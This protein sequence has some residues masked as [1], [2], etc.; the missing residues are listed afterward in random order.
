MGVALKSRPAQELEP[1]APLASNL[2]WLLAQASHVMI[3]EMTAAFAEMGVSPRGHCVLSAASTGDFTQKEL[4]TMVGLDKTTMVVTLDE[5]EQAG[6]AE[7]KLSA[8]DRRA[9][10]IAVTP[11]GKKCIRK[12][13]KLVAQIQEDVL[14]SLPAGEREAFMDTLSTLVCNR[15]STPAACERAPRRRG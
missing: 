2:A 14:S 13:E 12:G 3:T 1:S 6:L 11:D 7:R 5:L 9:R 4:A 15:L 10:I 8:T